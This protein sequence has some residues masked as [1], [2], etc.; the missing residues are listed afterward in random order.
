M[1]LLSLGKET[2]KLDFSLHC[3]C[4]LRVRLHGLWGEHENTERL[5]LTDTANITAL[6]SRTTGHSAV[7][8]QT[9]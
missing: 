9:T 3:R 6:T 5:L 2:W 7:D 1:C 8:W 4:G